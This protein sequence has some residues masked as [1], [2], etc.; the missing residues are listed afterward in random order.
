MEEDNNL[1]EDVNANSD[2]CYNN[3]LEQENKKQS[4]G[5]E[6]KQKNKKSFFVEYIRWPLLVLLI[7]LVLSFSFGVLSELALNGATIAI[8]IVVILV[9]LVLSVLTDIVGVAIT[10]VDISPFRA[11]SAKKVAGAKEAV[12][13]IKNEDHFRTF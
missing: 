10:A 9:F 12:F 8:A 11:M 13:L 3:Q 4:K 7:V 2:N 1:S 5:Q 6:K